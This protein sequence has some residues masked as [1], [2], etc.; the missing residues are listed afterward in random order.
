MCYQ[1]NTYICIINRITVLSS[2]VLR[3]IFKLLPTLKEPVL[4]IT[5]LYLASSLGYLG[6][7]WLIK[8]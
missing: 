6:R 8:F 7:Y 2:Q 4:Y 3:L 5:I 1:C